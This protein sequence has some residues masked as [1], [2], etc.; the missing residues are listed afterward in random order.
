MAGMPEPFE[1]ADSTGGAANF[2]RK[3]EGWLNPAD[4]VERR[5]R[6]TLARASV[7][8]F[9]AISGST[10]HSPGAAGGMSHFDRHWRGGSA[11]WWPRITRA[12][13]DTQMGRALLT[14]LDT[15]LTPG[16]EH[17][18]IRLSWDC[19]YRDLNAL[20][21]FWA[22]PTERD[23]VVWINIVSPRS[24]DG[25]DPESG[26]RNYG[27]NPVSDLEP[28][29]IGPFTMLGDREVA[30]YDGLVGVDTSFDHERGEMVTTK[31]FRE[32]W[33]FFPIAD[34]IENGRQVLTGLSYTRESWRPDPAS[35]G[36]FEDVSL[37][38]ETGY[39]LWDAANGMA[40]RVVAVPRG[41]SLL[42]VAHEVDRDA[43][44]VRFA[45]STDPKE[46]VGG[47]LS[48]PMMAGSVSTERFTSTMQVVDEGRAFVYEDTA[49]QRRIETDETIRHTNTNTLTRV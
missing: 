41:V 1:T 27:F 18:K 28:G 22:T 23:G 17:L 43:A 7:A 13:V 46:P 36:G 32:S 12:R 33:S 49:E 48:N 39:L 2:F 9:G 4:P 20:E 37:H 35:E 8:N 47:I 42:A 14:A 26:R 16:K 45:A 15:V 3:V 24:P 34:P 31:G 40:F 5:N 25:I 6:R 19:T 30:N 38:S 11:G 44:E 21:H 10:T 29:S